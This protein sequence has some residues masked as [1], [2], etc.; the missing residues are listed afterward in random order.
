MATHSSILDWRIPWTEEP[1]YGPWVRK[2]LYLT[3]RLTFSLSLLSYLH[4]IYNFTTSCIYIIPPVQLKKFRKVKYQMYIRKTGS[5]S[6][7]THY[8]N[9]IIS[10]QCDHKIH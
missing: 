2:E 5:C 3:E 10:S 4:I 9:K 7:V 1:G 6:E 8:S